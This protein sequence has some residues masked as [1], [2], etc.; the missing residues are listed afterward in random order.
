MYAGFARLSVSNSQGDMNFNKKH[1]HSPD[2]G[3]VFSGAIRRLKTARFALVPV[4]VVAA[5]S[6][7]LS[8]RAKDLAACQAEADRF[9]QG[10][11]TMDV[12]NP[13][14]RFIISCMADKG[15]AFNFTPKECDSRYPLPSQ[16]ACY[17][18][19]GWLAWIV[20]GFFRN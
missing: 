14:S 12:N 11:R 15:Y 7:C 3:Q 8:D 16:P 19:S 18:A 9:Y 13:R 6:G 20:D 5:V 2:Q 17:A 4:V 10:Y 1:I